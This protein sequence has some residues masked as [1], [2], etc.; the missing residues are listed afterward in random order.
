M[1]RFGVRKQN[2]EKIS[3]KTQNQRF[4]SIKYLFENE[5]LAIKK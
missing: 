2:L 5:F 3:E 4:K 1:K